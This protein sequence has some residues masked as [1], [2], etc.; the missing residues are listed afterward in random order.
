MTTTDP[1]RHQRVCELFLAVS[2]ASAGERAAL[3]DRECGDDPEIRAEVESLLSHHDS[4]SS[5]ID[6][7]VFG[8]TFPSIEDLHASGEA[9]Q[10]LPTE[11][12]DYRIREVLG[13]GG[14]GVVYLAEQRRPRRTVAL[15]VLRPGL[16]TP[17]M[18]RRFEREMDILGRL[19][20]PGIAQILEAG[21]AETGDGA[22]PF[23]AMEYVRGRPLTEYVEWADLPTRR[24]LELLVEICRAVQHAHQHGVVH[25][26][27]KPSNIVVD[28]DGRPK[29]LDFG[30]AR[31][32]DADVQATTLHTE[33]GQL[34]GTI[35][36]MSPEQVAGDP[37]CIDARADVYALGVLGF[38]LLTGRLPHDV[39]GKSIPEAARI[40]SDY[41]PTPLRT[42]SRTY[43]G[44]VDTI[45]AKALEKDPDRRYQSAAELA[46]DLERHL[47]DQPIA[48]R[49]PSSVYQLRKFARRNKALVGAIAMVFI[50]LAAASVV[51]T[52]FAVQALRSRDDAVEAKLD[53]ENAEVAE[54]EQRQ[55][56]EK[57]LK[58]AEAVNDFL[59][60]DLLAQAN[61]T[62]TSDR[63]ITL[64][65]VL[66]TA[67]EKIEDRF[68]DSPLVRA[69]I[70]I[71]LARTYNSLGLYDEARHHVREAIPVLTAELGP[72]DA[73][74]VSA[75]S[76]LVRTLWNSGRESE[77]LP[78]ARDTLAVAR[79]ELGDDHP[80]T[81][82]AITQM[83]VLL[84]RTGDLSDADAYYREALER[85]RRVHGAEAPYTLLVMT[86]YAL[87]LSDLKRH[88]EAERMN[89]TVLD[90]R[91][92]TLGEEHPYTLLSMVNQGHILWKQGKY[93]ELEELWTRAY[94]IRRRVLGEEHPETLRSM[95][96]IVL[97]Y[98]AKGQ[99]EVAEQWARRTLALR[100]KVLGEDH[101][102]TLVSLNSV[103]VALGHQGRHGDAEP[104]YRELLTI[105]QERDGGESRL[106]RMVRRNL[107]F[108]LREQGKLEEV[109]AVVAER[110]ELLRRETEAPDA[111]VRDFN[112]Y[113]WILLTCEPEEL[114]DPVAAL[115]AAERA[116]ELTEADDPEVLDTLALA[117]MRNGRAD[118]AMA[119]QRTAIGLVPPGELRLRSSLERNLA[120]FLRE[121]GDLDAL[122]S[123]H[124]SILARR[125][126]AEPRDEPAIASAQIGLANVLVDRNGFD[127]AERLL[128]AAW[129]TIADAAADDVD[130]QRT[131]L[132]ALVRLYERWDRPNEAAEWSARRTTIA[133][134]S[135]E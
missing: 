69:T 3:L 85:S 18:L 112:R 84:K 93:D 134:Q 132:D 7:P 38:E 71:T 42:I 127:E 67:S 78:L 49:P 13:R 27:L 53:A 124:R 63:E 123:L 74:T 75:R 96:A 114:R 133:N 26:D 128:L 61:P 24:R 81:I 43:R 36:Y 35:G 94:E 23:F 8:T 103:A 29:I 32:I 64:R 60:D 107:I 66:D 25:R 80:T 45:I 104:I 70:R 30:I 111:G 52:T 86:D 109:R 131:A 33:I 88:E 82:E 6:T 58:I 1:D 106:T 14:M 2:R 92:R 130:E 87:L 17:M 40:M 28:D 91:M 20:H 90:I 120:G 59:N 126:Q 54:I 68:A 73:E 98:E 65:Q 39:S 56:A 62:N 21:T 115:H 125:S 83:A 76:I 19:Q 37:R 57:R 99:S 122:E 116:V 121:A 105:L 117:L 101:P 97:L 119:T 48:A 108:T 46:A 11:I 51:S 77:A 16:L 9:D 41:E 4:E 50:V 47:A 89:R 135:P 55:L 79:T 15:K 110:L 44:D 102:D 100:R 72:A 113:A 5:P 10:T 22:Q 31:S 34:L 129:E 118:E 12:G 95:H